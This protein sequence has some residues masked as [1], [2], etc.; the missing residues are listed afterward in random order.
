M[1]ETDDEIEATQTSLAAEAAR[2]RAAIGADAVL[3]LTVLPANEPDKH[4]RLS[5]RA[6]NFFTALGAVH[7]WLGAEH[8]ADTDGAP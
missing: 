8:H 3:I 7:D 1:S 2:I 5:G 6:G 4:W